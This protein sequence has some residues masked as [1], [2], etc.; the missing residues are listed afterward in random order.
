MKKLAMLLL[1]IAGS[2]RA[3]TIPSTANITAQDSGA[4]S[5]AGACLVVNVPNQAASS[6]VQLTGTWSA[7]IQF[8]GT[9]S[10][11]GTFVAVN[12]VP[13]GGTTAVTS[14]T[15]N[16]AWRI[17]VAGL[18]QVRVRC[19]AVSS[20]PAVAAITL[21]T[22]SS[23]NNTA[24]GGAGAVSSVF[25]RTG[26]VTAQ[27]G[28][29]T[30]DQ[31]GNPAAAK[32]FSMGS[33][34]PLA[35]S[36]P[37]T[38][39]SSGAPH[40]S[41]QTI[42]TGGGTGCGALQVIIGGGLATDGFSSCI[43]TP[44]SSVTNGLNNAISGYTQLNDSSA[45]GQF[46][47][48]LGAGIFGV[49][50]AAVASTKCI[51]MAPQVESVASASGIVLEGEEVNVFPRNTSD[52]GYGLLVGML[53][54]TNQPT[55]DNMPA[56]AIQTPTGSATY[57]TDFECQDAS[58][59]GQVCLHVGQLATGL[60][61][62]SQYTAWYASDA[63]AQFNTSIQLQQ[64]H[65]LTVGSLPVINAGPGNNATY[66]G[67]FG[68]T[69]K[70]TSAIGRNLLVKPDTSNADSIVI[71]TTSDTTACIGFTVSD[72]SPGTCN[73]GSTFCAI[74]DT[75]G[76]LAKGILGTG[77]CAVGNYVIVDTTTNGDIKCTASLPAQGAWKGVALSAQSTVG[78]TV[79]VLTKFQ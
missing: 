50:Y 44:S 67:G 76:G 72:S 77:T 29:Y 66:G 24:G 78:Q 56:V 27:S 20:G 3:Q 40:E 58:A 71:C 26:A 55:G 14:A 33:N 73:A 75:P 9:T 34:L 53:G 12:A 46:G 39:T 65:Y 64:S 21:S 57:T 59:S 13:V 6:V 49:C 70:S 69:L 45:G 7:T 19:S 23:A 51:G 52:T 68:I 63:S 16:G 28:D 37:G 10:V 18:A 15:G 48:V 2:V 22:G 35:F 5:T 17:A 25:T 74:V 32:T 42:L 41:H 36:A 11:G 60:S 38:F 54:A 62:N 4:C 30:L 31:V 1:L 8:E 43:D 61:Q 47:K 79:D